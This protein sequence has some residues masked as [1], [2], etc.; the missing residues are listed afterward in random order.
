M[1]SGV[2]SGLL[3]GYAWTEPPCVT[4]SRTTSLDGLLV[5]QD[6]GARRITKQRS[7]DLRGEFN[8]IALLKWQTTAKYG[9]NDEVKETE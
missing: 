3:A 4:V 5:L 9:S 7:E 1:T 2:V 8:Y 6:F